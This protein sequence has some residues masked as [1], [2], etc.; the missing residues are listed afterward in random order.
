[1]TSNR[2]GVIG[3]SVTE[4]SQLMWN[5]FRATAKS[6]GMNYTRALEQAAMMWLARH[7]GP[8]GSPRPVNPFEEGQAL[9]VAHDLFV[10]P[11]PLEGDQ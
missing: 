3:A 11:L 8:D 10:D 1:M 7:T 6:L 4:E 5:T 9:P 2:Y